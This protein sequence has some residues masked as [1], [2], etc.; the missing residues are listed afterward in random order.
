M[1]NTGLRN[2]QWKLP[3][4][5]VVPLFKSPSEVYETY[6]AFHKNNLINNL[7]GN[8]QS[9]ALRYQG[10]GRKAKTY[11]PD[12]SIYENTQPLQQKLKQI[13]DNDGE[14]YENSAFHNKPIPPMPPVSNKLFCDL[15]FL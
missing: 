11:R 9:F 13:E 4:K 7:L 5:N 15:Y 8:A 12:E 6:T 14:I 10:I 2:L 1:D 3:V